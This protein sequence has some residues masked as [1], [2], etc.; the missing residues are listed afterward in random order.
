MRWVVVVALVCGC[1]SSDPLPAPQPRYTG[2]DPFAAAN[3]GA[4]NVFIDRLQACERLLAAMNAAAD[5]LHCTL[6]PSPACPDL[7]DAAEKKLGAPACYRYDEGVIANCEHRIETYV[8]CDDFQ[9]RPCSAL[10]MKPD[11]TGTA[12][13]SADA[14]TDAPG[15]G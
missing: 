10:R 3:D 6:D 1:S 15:G 5:Y 8:S 14:G 4:T 2:P 13:T 7:V 9:T 12:C 11:S